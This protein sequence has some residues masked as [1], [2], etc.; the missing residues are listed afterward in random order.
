MTQVKS[1]QGAAANVRNKTTGRHEFAKVNAR[2]PPSKGCM[3]PSLST[4]QQQISKK[5]GILKYT[6]TKMMKA[7]VIA[8][9]CFLEHN[10]FRSHRVAV[11]ESG[12]RHSALHGAGAYGL[13]ADIWNVVWPEANGTSPARLEIG[14]NYSGGE[15]YHKVWQDLASVSANQITHFYFSLKRVCCVTALWRLSGSRVAQIKLAQ[16]R[17]AWSEMFHVR[18]P[19]WNERGRTQVSG[20]RPHAGTRNDAW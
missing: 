17:G 11:C 18:S 12:G 15:L 20:W 3:K 16:R 9:R 6:F 2:Y 8:L 4:R 1:L 5:Q 7:G 14:S 19:T 10:L 13:T